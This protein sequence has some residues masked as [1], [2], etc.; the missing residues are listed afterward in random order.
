MIHI[1]W[2][3][4]ILVNPSIKAHDLPSVFLSLIAN[5]IAGDA[6][7]KNEPKRSILP[8]NPYKIRDL[9]SWVKI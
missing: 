3:W 9:L 2:S 6:L 7:N 1:R 4:L 5:R 8:S